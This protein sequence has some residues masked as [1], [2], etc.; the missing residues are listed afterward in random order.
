MKDETEHFPGDKCYIFDYVN[1]FYCA[2]YECVRVPSS[3]ELAVM[4]KK[5]VKSR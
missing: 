3:D 2:S 4:W 1:G 5:H